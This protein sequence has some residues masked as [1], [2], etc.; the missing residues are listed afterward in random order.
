MPLLLTK[1]QVLLLLTVLCSVL[2]LASCSGRGDT[3]PSLVVREIDPVIVSTDLAVGTN[4]FVIGLI[5]RETKALVLDARLHFRFFRL[6]NR[7]AKEILKAE[8]DARPLTIQKS[9]THI[10]NDGT[11]ETHEAGAIGIYIARVDFDSPGDW[12]VEVTGTR[13]GQPLPVLT[14]AFEVRKGSLSVA[15]GKSAP[16]TVQPILRDVVDVLSLDTSNPPDPHMHDM[17]IA[18]AV[19]SALPTV[20][21]F[22][23][24]DFC[25]SRTCGPTKE[26]V[27]QL[28]EK[29]R[30]QANFIH[31]EPYDIRKA[32][33]GEGLEPVAAMAE[34]GLRTEPWVFLVDREG[35][36]AAKFDGIVGFDELEAAFKPLLISPLRSQDDIS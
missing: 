21:V 14:P 29:Y 6:E 36:V 34:W 17:T 26:M 24:P 9:Y 13:D 35:V 11:I 23:T 4:R 10:H 2:V 7:G 20:I 22:A 19:R 18:A 28:Y 32:R 12:G 1:P 3:A 16:R 15:P 33:S 25:H 8:A 27:D 5:D 31:V 30:G